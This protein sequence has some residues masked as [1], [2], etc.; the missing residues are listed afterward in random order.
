MCKYCKDR[1]IVEIPFRTNVDRPMFI[2]LIAI[3]EDGGKELVISAQGKAYGL[4]IKYCPMCGEK[5]SK[6]KCS[7]DG[8]CGNNCKCHKSVEEAFPLTEYKEPELTQEQQALADELQ[9]RV[10]EN[11]TGPTTFYVDT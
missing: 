6:T 9:R 3:K 11:R 10:A 7:C 2:P 4:Q 8:N 5:L 1:T